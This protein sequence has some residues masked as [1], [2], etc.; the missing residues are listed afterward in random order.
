MIKIRIN[1]KIYRPTPSYLKIARFQPKIPIIQIAIKLTI[2]KIHYE[3]FLANGPIV[4]YFKNKF[5][6]RW[7]SQILE[8]DGWKSKVKTG[9]TVIFPERAGEIV[10]IFSLKG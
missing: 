10:P 4:A 9:K 1:P 8:R 2:F 3:T 5:L 7:K 6:F